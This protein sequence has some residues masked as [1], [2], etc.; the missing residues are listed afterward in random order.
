MT[1]AAPSRDAFLLQL[2]RVMEE[3][4]GVEEWWRGRGYGYEER[5]G[6]EVIGLSGWEVMHAARRSGVRCFT[7]GFHRNRF[8]TVYE[9]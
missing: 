3:S 5:Q 2:G 4:V 1:N 7:V 9:Q 6:V 8:K